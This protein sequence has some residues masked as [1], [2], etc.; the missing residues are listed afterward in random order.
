MLPIVNEMLKYVDQC[1]FIHVSTCCWHL[2]EAGDS[3]SG[4]IMIHVYETTYYDF[5]LSWIVF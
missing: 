3:L 1:I 5:I 4:D 2:G